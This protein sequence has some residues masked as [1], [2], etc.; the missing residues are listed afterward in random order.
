MQS[1]ACFTAFLYF[2]GRTAETLS[3]VPAAYGLAAAGLGIGVPL[4]PAFSHGGSAEE[5]FLPVF[6]LSLYTVLKAMRERRPP[7]GREAFLLGA[8]AAAALWTKYTFCGLYAGLA[9]AAAVWD[10][11]DYRGRNLLR[12][13]GQALA[14]AGVLTAAI[15]IRYAA[16]GALPALWQAYFLDNL[17]RYSANIRG[18][19]YAMPLPNLLNNLSWSVPAFLGLAWLAGTAK[20]RWREAAACG[21]GAAALFIFTY[22]SGRRYPYYALVMAPFGA[23]GFAALP[24]LIP[25]K[26]GGRLPGRTAAGLAALILLAGLPAAAARGGN[27]YLLG[28]KKED[29]PQYRFAETIRQ[30]TGG[31]KISP[32]KVTFIDRMK[33]RLINPLFYRLFVKADGFF[34]TDDC[35]G[36]GICAQLCP[37]R[38]ITIVGEKPVWGQE[39]THCMACICRCP[40]EAVE[41]GKKSEGKPRYYF[42]PERKTDYD[43]PE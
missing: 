41:Y 36:C 20:K 35:T 16:A 13:A 3:G 25:G 22:A 42:E 31:K 23:A 15:L 4:S 9:L 17:T 11:A 26:T 10:I 32:G 29:M 38:N 30:I 21:I 6:A 18:G 1:L 19:N 33:S 2:S 8:C 34:T 5:L 28:T 27:T 12:T 43:E 7:A 37:L 39:C 24:A 14:G 40:A